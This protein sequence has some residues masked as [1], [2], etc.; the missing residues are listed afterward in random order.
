[1]KRNLITIISVLLL[2]SSCNIFKE[3]IDVLRNDLQALQEQVDRMNSEL[4]SLQVLV[5][6]INEH[7]LVESVT[8]IKENDKEIGFVIKFSNGQDI[9]IYHGRDGE[10]GHSPVVSVAKHT[11]GRWYWTVD[12]EWLKDSNGNM[13]PAAAKDGKDG[14]TPR[15]KIENGRWY[16]SYDNGESWVD[17]GQAQGD[18]GE[19]GEDGK[20]LFESVDYTSDPNFVIFTLADG[21]QF[22]LHT[23]SVFLAIEDLCSQLNNNIASLD[24]IISRKE[25]GEPVKGYTISF[26][27]NGKTAFELTYVNNSRI[28]LYQDTPEGEP[29]G[30]SQAPVIGMAENDGGY[31]WTLNGEKLTDASGAEIP[32]GGGRI[33]KLMV[34]NSRWLISLDNKESW[35][36]LGPITEYDMDTMVASIDDTASELQYILTLAGGT[37]IEIPKYQGISLRWSQKEDILIKAGESVSVSFTIEGGWGQPYVSTMAT[38]GWQ[39]TI[40]MTDSKNGIITVTAPK[41]YSQNDVTLFINCDGQIIMESLTFKE[42]TVPVDMVEISDTLVQMYCHY[43]RMLSAT[44]YPEEARANEIIWSTSDSTVVKVSR[45]GRITAVATGTSVI[46][47]KAGDKKAECKVNVVEPDIRVSAMNIS[48]THIEMEERTNFRLWAEVF[49][50]N[51]TYK[52]IFWESTNP[53]IAKIVND[54]T[55]T[56]MALK[57]GKAVITAKAG[58]IEQACE[59]EVIPS[60]V[61]YYPDDEGNNPAYIDVQVGNTGVSFRMILVNSGTFLM[62]NEE[63]EEDERPVHQ[64]TISNDYYIAETEVTQELYCAVMGIMGYSPVRN[65]GDDSSRPMIYVYDDKWYDFD[66]FFDRLYQLTGHHFRLPTEAEWE[67]AARGGNHSKGYRYSGSD[68]PD[69]VAWWGNNSMDGFANPV[70][71]FTEQQIHP[72]KSK[73]PNE[74]GIYDMSGN[75]AEICN[76]WYGIYPEDP[77]TDPEGRKWVNDES[78][79]VKRG[80]GVFYGDWELRVTD[81]MQ[82]CDDRMKGFRL[83]L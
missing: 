49:P 65:Y 18:K 44:V 8:P 11:D 41:P 5:Q 13:V 27:G 42:E 20:S 7:A 50:T 78:C 33:P 10:H 6:A 45:N 4:T 53:E 64:V 58:E 35:K 26:D 62:G 23:Y 43:A 60:T 39:A 38:N 34:K 72:V 3:E 36:D 83:A 19:N 52:K 63:G 67:F 22:K 59:V 66:T 70:T 55:G 76:D 9:T 12:G 54:S 32:V 25:S 81:R 15:L 80:G 75:V 40:D 73:K 61:S 79:R 71:G 56:V 1:M 74:L 46:T 16:L 29:E 48:H 82:W 69:E 21:T 14:V 68:D 24:M 31:I 37:A 28:L 57:P 2:I 17:A 30:E 77:V 51:A 47:A